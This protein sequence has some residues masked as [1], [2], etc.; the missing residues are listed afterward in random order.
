MSK[1]IELNLLL[2]A[3]DG[4]SGIVHSAVTKSDGDF[5]ALR[6]QIKKTADT[7][8]DIGNKSAVMGGA[9]AAASGLNAKAAGD[10][11][12]GMN[13]VSTLI[14][15]NVE[16][17]GAMKKELLGIAKES[18]KAIA[19]LT[20]G[21]YNIRSAGVDAADQ[22]KVLKASE[23]L[24]VTG[25]SSTA[26]SVDVLTSTLN[27]FNLKGDEALNVANVFL[28][29]V[30]AGKTNMA[31]F[32]QGFGSV[33][34]VVAS[35]GIK[36][37][38]YGAAVAAMTTT[39]LKANNAHTQMSA[40]LS[41]LTRSSKEQV[42]IFNQLG[43][44]S[45]KDLVAKSG[46]MVNAFKRIDKAVG[47]NEAKMVALMGSIN[48][49]KAVLGLT[50]SVNAKFNETLDYM[51]GG[52]DVLGEAYDK[53]LSGL[54]M[55]LAVTKN[56]LQALSISFGNGLLPLLKNTNS[57]IRG[58][59][60]TL[61]K[62]PEPL[63]NFISVSTMTA[64]A[65]LLAF[66]TLS[67]AAGS[68]IRSFGD[69]LDAYRE[70]NIWL[71]ANPIKIPPLNLGTF[72][73]NLKAHGDF[74]KG[75]LGSTR[76]QFALTRASAL[77]FGGGL[78][79]ALQTPVNF[80]GFAAGLKMLGKAWIAPTQGA[81]AFTGALLTNPITW[82][83]AAVVAGGLL[84]YK[85]WQP[86]SN[87]FK[88]VWSGAVEATKPLHPLFEKIST[89]IQPVINWFKELIKPVQD[90][91]SAAFNLGVTVGKAIGGAIT[92]I[93]KMTKKLWDLFKYTQP[94]YWIFK[95]GK[96]VLD[97]K[98]KG[99]EEKDKK[100]K[101]K[102]EDPNP[103]KPHKTGL[104]NVPYDGYRAILHKNERVLTAEENKNYST[105]N[106]TG[107]TFVYGPIIQLMGEIKEAPLW[108]KDLLKKH[109]EEIMYRLKLEQQRMEA[110]A[111]AEF[112]R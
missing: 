42:E 20:E 28:K 68:A 76:T 37:D 17:L 43:A 111:Y 44:K 53:Q 85:Y 29:V 5:K 10:F 105:E 88:G 15:T 99:K 59:I 56:N 97:V 51:R 79:T 70:V 46:G 33:A 3:R 47:G 94:L 103:G 12:Q 4:L 57:L 31:E 36:I 48:G 55:Q 11:E 95:G 101:E 24:A 93:A 32:A 102:N 7:F 71:W 73:G 8:S 104:K 72:R 96:W 58:F 112:C 90:V 52:A 38:E 109:T 2:K 63:K 49:Y 69:I 65:G 86:I 78:K 77:A 45:F 64:G 81:L 40:A 13:N 107:I 100:D 30:K 106:K 108:L 26:E 92:W 18:P 67:I 21:L 35:S 75:I 82:I 9:L 22:F 98:N 6:E 16:N 84:I 25:L 27:A 74:I 80:E 54:N 19:D 41:S 91:D 39:G 60:T 23:M 87:F 1:S 66:G 83:A 110:R 89:A 34:G 62:M 50:N 61:D 14:D